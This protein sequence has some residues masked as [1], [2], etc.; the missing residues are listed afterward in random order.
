M[1]NGFKIGA[2]A[3][4][5]VYILSILFLP[6]L[7]VFGYVI[8]GSTLISFVSWVYLPLVAGVVIIVCSLA[9]P[10]KIGGIVSIV[11]AVIA[12]ISFFIIRSAVSGLGLSAANQIAGGSIPMGMG[13]MLTQFVQ[14]GF[15][16]ILA[17]IAGAGSAVLCFLSEGN[18][19][20]PKSQSVGLTSDN[21]DEW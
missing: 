5:A 16:V 4:G 8:N 20:R 9:C 14:V 2:A 6:F 18:M 17:M 15:G 11:C 21:G 19:V 12:L 13:G 3:C 1:I 10:G 7:S